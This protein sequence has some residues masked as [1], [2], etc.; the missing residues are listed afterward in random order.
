MTPGMSH[1]KGHLVNGAPSGAHDPYRVKGVGPVTECAAS[2][3]GMAGQDVTASEPNPVTECFR[4]IQ[5][6]FHA[7]CAEG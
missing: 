2:P 1:I 3:G 6:Y 4:K 5:E 7:A